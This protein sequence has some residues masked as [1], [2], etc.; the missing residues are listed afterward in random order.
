MEDPEELKGFIN[1]TWYNTTDDLIARGF[2]TDELD[3]FY[4]YSDPTQFGY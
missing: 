3:T 4:D 1:G 2:T